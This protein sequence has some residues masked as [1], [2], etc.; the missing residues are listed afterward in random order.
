MLRTS[1]SLRSKRLDPP[2][3][4]NGF[5]FGVVSKVR[6]DP[7]EPTDSSNCPIQYSP[8]FLHPIAAGTPSARASG[9][10]RLIRPVRHRQVACAAKSSE[11]VQGPPGSERTR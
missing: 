4:A 8:S 1:Q 3:K 11:K 10:E 9:I 6:T 2:S 5:S 7:S